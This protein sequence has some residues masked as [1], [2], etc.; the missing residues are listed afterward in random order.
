MCLLKCI[1]GLVSEN[2]LAVN[3]LIFAFQARGICKKN[4]PIHHKDCKPGFIDNIIIRERGGRKLQ[5]LFDMM[6]SLFKIMLTITC[7]TTVTLHDLFV[8]GSPKMF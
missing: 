8:R 2:P 5:Y 4:V 6:F 1:K 7:T 3:V